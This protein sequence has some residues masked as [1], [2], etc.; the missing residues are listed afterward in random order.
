MIVEIKEPKSCR[1]CFFNVGEYDVD[2]YEK[3][4]CKNTGHQM[5]KQDYKKRPKDCP[6]WNNT[7]EEIKIDPD[8]MD[9][10]IW[11]DQFIKTNTSLLSSNNLKQLRRVQELLK[12]QKAKIEKYESDKRWDEYPD[13]MGRY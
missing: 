9:V 6:L 13:I 8:H 10:E 5:T 1:E 12:E 2:Y 3:H 4:Y 11:F 7:F